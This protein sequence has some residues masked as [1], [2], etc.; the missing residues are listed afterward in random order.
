MHVRT[1]SRRARGLECWFGRISRGRRVSDIFIVG[2]PRSGTSWLRTLLA[3][4][5]T[6]A[7]PHELHLFDRYLIPA[8]RA[9]RD[10]SSALERRRTAGLSSAAG[11][12]SLLQYDELQAWMRD[13]YQRSRS[14][15][16]SR[17]PGATHLLEKTP[18]N[19]RHL[20]LIRAI[21]PG[22]KFVH[23]VRDPR[24]VVASMIERSRRPFGEWA[25]GEVTRATSTWRA[26]VSAGLRDARPEDTILVRYEDLRGDLDRELRRLAD[27]LELEGAVDAWLVGD[28][29]ARAFERSRS[30]TVARIDPS[31]APAP[32]LQQGIRDLP[33]EIGA[34]TTR[35]LSG[36]ARWYIESRCAA[37]MAQLGYAP[38]IWRSDRPQPLW[39]LAAAVD[40]GLRPF[41]RRLVRQANKRW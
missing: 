25:P 27:F 16:L 22:A 15:A 2:S 29:G 28:P 30:A 23:L 5:P 14:A 1:T 19:A 32:S 13:L 11:L 33:G 17:K 35:S 9:W 31:A 34:P 3:G 20:G 24:A 40:I 38:Q 18:E 4:H 26:H 39:A 41:G 8:E 36:A 12:V 21:V 6:L 7:S 10:E 37:E